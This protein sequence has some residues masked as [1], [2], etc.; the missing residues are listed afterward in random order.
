MVPV[1]V[2][3]QGVG[4]STGLAAMVPAPDFFTEVSFHEDDDDLARKMRGKLLAEISELRG[5]NT[6]AIEGIRAF[7]TRKHENWVPK[8]REFATTYPRRA[9]FMGTTN[10]DAFLADKEGNR[11]WLPVRVG[12]SADV[13]AVCRDRLQLWAEGRELFKA[14]GVAFRD[15]EELARAV[16]A[17]HTVTDPWTEEIAR[18]L[19]ETDELTGDTPGEREFLRVC[20]VARFALRLE[21]KQLRRC[22]ELR[23]CNSLQELGYMRDRGYVNGVQVRVWKRKQ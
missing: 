17:E 8:F 23:I 15:A 19:A 13:E 10:E 9:V 3:A 20:D 18:W 1:L 16:H 11:R 7:V 5:L 2:G 12:A 6:R 14:G 4:K 22:E 21:A